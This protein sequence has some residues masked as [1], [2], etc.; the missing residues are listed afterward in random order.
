M[1]NLIG[2]KGENLAINFLKDSGFKIRERNYHS[3]WGEI[4]II[5]EKNDTLYFIEVKTRQKLAFGMPY[6]AINFYKTKAL[7]RCIAYYIKKENIKNKKFSFS[8]ISIIL[9]P[10]LTKSIIKLY[11]YNEVAI[12]LYGKNY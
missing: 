12:N 3:R 11:N 7:K 4:D 1:T 8:V 10:D 2:I 5:A 6:E 9:S